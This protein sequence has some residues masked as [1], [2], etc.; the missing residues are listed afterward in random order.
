M[1]HYPKRTKA[2]GGYIE[3]QL[4]KGE[5]YYPSLIKLN[6]G[7]NALEYI[8]KVNNYSS[9]YIP[10]FTCE[11]VLEPIKKLGI[12][13]YFYTIDKNLDPVID[14]HIA[15]TE[16]F[17]YTNYF[18]IK[19]LTVNKLSREIP[20]LIIDASQ[21]FFSKPLPEIDTFY[22]CRKF[23]GV[24]DGAYLQSNI[25]STTKFEKD[26]SYDRISHLTKSIDLSIE[27]GYKNFI[28]NNKA[29][30]HNPIKRMSFLTNKILSSIDYE[31]CRKIRN[32]NFKTLHQALSNN[33][34]LEINFA[35][36]DAP[37]CYPLLLEKETISKKLISKRVYIPTFWPNVL[38]WTTNKMFENYLTQHL[39]SL[40][41]DHRYDDE[42]MHRLI[43]YLKQII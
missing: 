36:D 32:Q 12:P 2:I 31:E 3:L 30:D 26:V 20:N 19:Q 1:R 17:L 22:S 29:L 25:L 28:E 40:P 33:N 39:V 38:R 5:E 41:I 15:P 42:D 14:F 21:A 16:C 8:L 37:M 10:Y 13:Y 27:E 35:D 43:N 6:T 23:F 24:A 11:V 18:G 7:R 34:H 9:I 4:P